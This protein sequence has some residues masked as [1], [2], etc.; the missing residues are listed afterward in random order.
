MIN[1]FPDMDTYATEINPVLLA[2]R[3]YEY[4]GFLGDVNVKNTF[5]SHIDKKILDIFYFFI[6]IHFRYMKMHRL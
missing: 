4:D 6:F 1:R 5:T 3:G 2:S